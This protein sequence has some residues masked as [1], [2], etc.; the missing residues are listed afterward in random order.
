MRWALARMHAACLPG[1]EYAD[2]KDNS[3]GGLLL[4]ATRARKGLYRRRE[5]DSICASRS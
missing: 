4:Q 2:K 3:M 5:R 1:G